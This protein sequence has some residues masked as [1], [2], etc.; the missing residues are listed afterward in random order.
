MMRM[1]HKLLA[2]VLAMVLCLGLFGCGTKAPAENPPVATEPAAAE[3]AVADAPKED[4]VILYTN[5]V[6]TYIDNPLSY[7]VIAGIKA[8]LEKTYGE[9]NVLLE[10]AGDHVQGTA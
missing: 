4:V 9:G 8:E 2:L 6:H 5:D 7:D 3:T 1:M 10:D